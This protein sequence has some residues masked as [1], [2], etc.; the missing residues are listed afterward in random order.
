LSPLKG[1][2]IDSN[3]SELINVSDGGFA[4][5]A[6]GTLVPNILNQSPDVPSC[7]TL[8]TLSQPSITHGLELNPEF[9]VSETEAFLQMLRIF[10]HPFIL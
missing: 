1:E 10:T 9:I 7:Q 2:S 4:V 3:P 8:F 5:S 6:L